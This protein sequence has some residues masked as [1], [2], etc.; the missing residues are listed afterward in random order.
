MIANK[1]IFRVTFVL[2]IN[3]LTLLVI[4]PQVWEM[5]TNTLLINNQLQ[6][7]VPNID[8]ALFA[9]AFFGPFF[10]DCFYISYIIPLATT[11][12]LNG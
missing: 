2:I 11:T 12:S 10:F 7:Q 1:N 9:A 6:H 4:V 5:M 8:Q 3:G